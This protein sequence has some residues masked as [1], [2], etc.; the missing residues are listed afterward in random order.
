MAHGTEASM[1]ED[2]GGTTVNVRPSNTPDA[3]EDYRVPMLRNMWAEHSK[4]FPCKACDEP[5]VEV[6]AYSPTWRGR[7]EPPV[8]SLTILHGADN[9]NELT[10]EQAEALAIVLCRAAHEAKRMRVRHA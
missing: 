2:I 8:V 3:G 6:Q 10:P 9:G 4:A 5:K 1:Q 7:G